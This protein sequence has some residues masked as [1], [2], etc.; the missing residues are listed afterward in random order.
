MII[1]FITEGNKSIGLGHIIRCLTIADHLK[2]T[3]KS[4]KI[5]FQCKSNL[6]RKIISMHGYSLLNNNYFF[7]NK[8]FS[9]LINNKNG[10]IITDFLDTDPSFIKKL[11]LLTK[12]K[13][14]C[15]DNNTNLKLLNSADIII[16]ANVF[17]QPEF[18]VIKDAKYFLGPKYMILRKEFMINKIK[19]QKIDNKSI[20]VL[21]GGTDCKNYIL[22]CI[23]EIINLET[24]YS[25]KVVVG[26]GYS[27]VKKLKTILQTRKNTFLYIFPNNLSNLMRSVN[28]AITAAGIVLYELSALRIPSI[29]IP[30]LKHQEEIA[31]EFQKR[32][33]CINLGRNPKKGLIN[34]VIIDMMNNKNMREKIALNAHKI[35]DGKGLIRFTN[36]ISNYLK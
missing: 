18:Q 25:I 21:F 27:N 32:K 20:L 29:T 16:N 6:C 15:I 31:N 2:E 19:K 34:T 35:V 24:S 12:S 9:K 28:I 4:L 11:R 22:K 23:D 10:I 3:D 13:I 17:N 14:I 33:A 5:Y 26:L 1:I 36:I 8:K 30:Q 7:I